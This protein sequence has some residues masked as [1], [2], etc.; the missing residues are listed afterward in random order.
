MSRRENHHF[1][2]AT[3]AYGALPSMQRFADLLV[4]AVRA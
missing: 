2:D 1:I 3:W 4:A